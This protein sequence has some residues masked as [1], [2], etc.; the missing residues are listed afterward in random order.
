[1]SILEFIAFLFGA[2]FI[3]SLIGSIIETINEERERLKKAREY[4]PYGE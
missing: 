4:E 3:I 1:M 2:L